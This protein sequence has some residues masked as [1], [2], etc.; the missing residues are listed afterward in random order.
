MNAKYK[1]EQIRNAVMAIGIY[2]DFINI[3]KKYP[4]N[5]LCLLHGRKKCARRSVIES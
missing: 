2:I 5:D 4:A 1:E 3:P